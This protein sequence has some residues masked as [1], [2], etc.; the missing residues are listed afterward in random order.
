M[1]LTVDTKALADALDWASKAIPQQKPSHPV[2]GNFKLE[3]NSNGLEVTGFDLS[4]A[5]KASVEADVDKCGSVTIPAKLFFETVKHLPWQSVLRSQGTPATPRLYLP[6][7]P[8]RM[9]EEE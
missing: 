6:D 3:A 2:L 7:K 4:M 1:R 5:I 9:P 8:A